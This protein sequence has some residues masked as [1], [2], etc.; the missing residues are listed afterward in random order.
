[1]AT[2]RRGTALLAL[3]FLGLA[4][5]GGPTSPGDEPRDAGPPP[6]DDAGDPNQPPTGFLDPTG[7][8]YLT[9]RFKGLIN[10]YETVADDYS[11]VITGIGSLK[12]AFLGR[13]LELSDSDGMYAY[14]YTYPDGN[15]YVVA[16]GSRATPDST[17]SKGTLQEA[18]LYFPTDAALALDDASHLVAGTI[19]V[20]LRDA[21]YV[22]RKDSSVLYKLCY[23]GMAGAGAQVFLDHS[24][25]Q[26]F[27]P[28]ENL[29]LWANVPVVTDRQVMI[30][31]CGSTCTRYQGAPCRCYLDSADLDCA[32]WDDEVQKDGTDLSCGAPVDFLTPPPS[33]DWATFKFKGPI[34]PADEASPQSGW[35]DARVSVGGAVAT[36]SM[37]GYATE[38]DPGTSAHLL[39]LSF[40]DYRE[41]AGGVFDV[42]ELDFYVAPAALVAAKAS[43]TDPIV[44]DADTPAMGL[45]LRLTGYPVGDDYVYRVCPYAVFR[46]GATAGS[47][48][49]CPAAN[50]AF[51]AGERLE[52]E[53]NLV[54]ETNVTAEDVGVTLEADG[55]YCSNGAALVACSTLPRS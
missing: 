35:V 48:F 18:N 16:S 25:N 46:P 43:A 54:L 45:A 40:Y 17:S 15:R 47:L 3:G 33:G 51:G 11:N 26:S 1:M 31:R 38:Y 37:F 28:G 6:Q 42:T 22:V 9:L 23:A 29:I 10:S 34:V 5:C 7:A 4:A 2:P 8:D 21:E 44:M 24:A 52:I 36:A 12:A 27:G 41:G 53:G 49:D 20:S 50:V 14:D 39:A 55:C 30:E 32:R 13:T 19:A